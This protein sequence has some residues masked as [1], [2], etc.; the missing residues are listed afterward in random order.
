MPLGSSSS[1]PRLDCN[2]V[3]GSH[4][5]YCAVISIILALLGMEAV[6]GLVE[7]RVVVFQCNL[8]GDDDAG[9]G[10][11]QLFLSGGSEIM[12]RTEVLLGSNRT[13]EQN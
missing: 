5:S 8:K 9:E 11:V 13:A 2:P 10:M 1:S 7:F 6:C 12:N 4:Q 3:V